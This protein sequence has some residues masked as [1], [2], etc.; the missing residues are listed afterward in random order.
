M[1]V[2]DY[3]DTYFNLT[4]K[5]H[6][7]F[8]WF[9]TFCRITQPNVL[10]IDDDVPFSPQQLVQVLA[11]M[12][13]KQRRTLF[14]GKVEKNAPVVRFGWKKNQKWALLK[15]EA[16]WPL[17]PTYLQGIYILAGFQHVERLALGM[18][19]TRYIP[20]EDAWIG[21]VAARLN[22]SLSSIH[23]YMTRE[24]MVIKKR[25]EFEPVDSKIFTR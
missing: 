10:F 15:E 21:L 18:L 4:V 17:Y 13:Q 1:V 7:S 8:M 24:N 3:E 22:I 5:T 11:S 12:S 16:P 9:S 20:I 25:S 6:Y 19:F 23:N 14:H 2:G